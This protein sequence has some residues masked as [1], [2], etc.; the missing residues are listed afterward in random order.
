MSQTETLERPAAAEAGSDLT[1][2]VD[3]P[4][5]G[6][7][8]Y[9]VLRP[10]RP[11]PDPAAMADVYRASSDRELFDQVVR[12]RGCELVYLHPRV[13]EDI[14]LKSYGDAEDPAFISQDAQRVRTF[15]RNLGDILRR[16]GVA[17]G[18][19]RRV[20]DVGCAGGAFPKAATELGLSATGVEPSRWLAEQ[21]RA[22]YGLDIRQGTLADQAFPPASFEIVTLWD[23]LE[24]LTRPRDVLRQA[25]ELL[26]P[27][28]LLIVSYPDY[29]SLARRLMGWRWPFFLS[30]HLVYF[31]PETVTKFLAT[32]GFE[33]L[34]IRPLWQTLEMGYVA[35]RASAVMPL[36]GLLPPLISALG[37]VNAAVTYQL[38]QSIV[39]ARRCA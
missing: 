34:E 38:G 1:D 36:L 12:C 4:L 13:R 5:C 21:G 7:R 27:G 17:I 31:T 8:R 14:I 24:H 11:V 15:R 37:L 35:Q 10:A 19:D 3:C 23:V 2:E 20:L 39:V 26:K 22:R 9:E 29:A 30:V 33:T 32:C 28:G 18:P 6:A 16:Q 25:H